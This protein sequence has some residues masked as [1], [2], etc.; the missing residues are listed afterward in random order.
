MDALFEIDV[1]G[2]G[3]VGGLFARVERLVPPFAAEILVVDDPSFLGFALVR[4]RALANGGHAANSLELVQ[5]TMQQHATNVQQKLYVS[6][7]VKGS[8]LFVMRGSGVQIPPAAPM[9]LPMSRAAHHL[10]THC[11]YYLADQGTDLRTM[12]I[13]SVTEIPSTRHTCCWASVRGALEIEIGNLN[14]K[15]MP[16]K[17]GKDD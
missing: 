2:G 8:A 11:G 12:Q 5:Q 6:R 13:T 9:L 15:Q 10:G 14:T 17:R 1:C 3:G 7:I 16:L 4:P